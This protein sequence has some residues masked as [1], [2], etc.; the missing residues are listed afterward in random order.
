MQILCLG[1]LWRHSQKILKLPESLTL[2]LGVSA[3]ISQVSP[4]PA[5]FDLLPKQPFLELTHPVKK[6]Q[7]A[8][9]V[10]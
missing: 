4:F 5:K 10:F 7:S 6:A 2:L 3:E 1:D 8:M 9:K